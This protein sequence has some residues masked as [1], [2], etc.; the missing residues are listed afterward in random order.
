MTDGN[1]QVA[2]MSAVAENNIDQIMEKWRMRVQTRMMI[3]G[4]ILA[5]PAVLQTISRAIRYPDEWPLSIALVIFYFGI[6]ALIFQKK[7]NVQTR[8]W[9]LI[10][11]LYLVGLVSMARGGLWGDGRI[12]LVLLPIFGV[13]LI[14][15]S[16][17][18]SLV[19]VSISTFIVFGFLNHIGILENWLIVKEVPMPTEIWFYDGLIFATLMITAIVVLVDFYKL[20]MTTLVN[21]RKNAQRLRDAHHLLDQTNVELERKVDQRTSE[22]AEANQRLYHLANHDSLTGL[23]NRMLFY[24]ELE[25]AISRAKSSQNYLAVVFIDLDNFKTINDTFGHMCGDTLLT[26]TA[27]RFKQRMDETDILARL[28]GDEF[29]IIIGELPSPDDSANVARHL[30]EALAEPFQIED[31]KPTLSA[32]IGISVFPIDAENADELVSHADT[33]MYRVKHSTK[34]DFLFYSTPN[35]YSN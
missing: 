31:S 7:I 2:K 13:L 30:L 23:P 24:E 15:V 34:G 21:E 12:Y 29:A 33:A 22:L 11:L 17:G 19:V 20:L 9:I 10:L 25:A 16:A 28:S 27:S 5:L 35:I 26:K 3:F 14:N 1:S 4:A 8:G 18:I 32:S 6:V